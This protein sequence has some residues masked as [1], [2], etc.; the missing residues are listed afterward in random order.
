MGRVGIHKGSWNLCPTDTEDNCTGTT[1]CL[2]LSPVFELLVG[3][4]HIFLHLWILTTQLN[5]WHWVER[6][7]TNDDLFLLYL[8]L[9]FQIQK[10]HVVSLGIKRLQ[11]YCTYNTSMGSLPPAIGK[12]YNTVVKNSVQVK[13]IQLQIPGSVTYWVSCTRLLKLSKSLR[14][15]KRIKLENA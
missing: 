1:H 4:W 5:T 7:W 8:P 12:L 2:L 3:R 13:H 14:A 9:K 15:V 6:K 11:H 10:E